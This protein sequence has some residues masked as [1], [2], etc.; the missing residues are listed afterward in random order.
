MNYLIKEC[1]ECKKTY[2]VEKRRFLV[3]KV[4]SYKCAGIIAS[5]RMK[6]KKPKNYAYFQTFNRNRL[7]TKQNEEFKTYMSKL[8]KNRRWMPPHFVGDQHWNWKGGKTELLQ[9]IRTSKKYL[10]DWR[11]AIYKRDNYI[12]T[13]CKY[14]QGHILEADHI[15]PLSYIVKKNNI[16]SVK[17]AEKCKEIWDISNGRALCKPCHKKTDTWGS[18]SRKWDISYSES[19]QKILNGRQ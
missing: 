7:G 19:T 6:G 5:R 11:D 9:R 14:D 16:T 17:E 1:L 10:V 3:S 8:S 4:C 13:K 12:C 2:N 15:I 18:K